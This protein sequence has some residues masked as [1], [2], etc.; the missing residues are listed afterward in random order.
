MKELYFLI[1]HAVGR[2][3][4]ATGEADPEAKQGAV[5]ALPTHPGFRQKTA[6]PFHLSYMAVTVTLR[7]LFK[8]R[9]A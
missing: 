4:N 7:D 9:K 1:C 8:Y 2:I 6:S 5:T 3:T